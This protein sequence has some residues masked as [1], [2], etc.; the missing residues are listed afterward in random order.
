MVANGWRFAGEEPYL[1]G[2]LVAR[3]IAVR[4]D[5]DRRTTRQARYRGGYV[6]TL[7]LAEG[8]ARA[9]VAGAVVWL[10]LVVAERIDDR[11]GDDQLVVVVSRVADPD[12]L[13]AAGREGREVRILPLE[14]TDALGS[15]AVSVWEKQ[16]TAIVHAPGSGQSR[17]GERLG[18]DATAVKV[19]VV[20]DDLRAGVRRADRS[21]VSLV[22]RRPVTDRRWRRG[23]PEIPRPPAQLLS[24]VE[25]AARP[26]PQGEVDDRAV[27]AVVP[28]A[29][30]RPVPVAIEA[31][32][33][34]VVRDRVTHEQARRGRGPR[35]PAPRG[36]PADKTVPSARRELA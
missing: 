20:R 5:H 22:R 31:H 28:H 14:S 12:G 1:F 16:V 11:L 32:D 26:P 30:V 25:E 33:D 19:R 35:T 18:P 24:N 29:E 10:E 17:V 23:R 21:K 6:A 36:F 3:Q 34:L 8:A 13:A 2:Q 15:D 4:C 7:A 9:G 27:V